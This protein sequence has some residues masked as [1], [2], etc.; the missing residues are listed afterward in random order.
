MSNIE[1]HIKSVNE[2]FQQLLKNHAALKK[3]NSNLKN[4]LNNL[5]EK[6]VEYKYS[7]HETEQKINILKVA[8]GQ[9]DEKDKKEFEIRINRYIKEIEKCIR[10]LSE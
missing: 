1:A 2:K 8:S 3:E 10:L 4:E 9:M 6:E 7:L 5:K